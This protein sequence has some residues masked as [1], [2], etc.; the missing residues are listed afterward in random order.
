MKN[1]AVHPYG[2]GGEEAMVTLCSVIRGMTEEQIDTIIYN[3]RDPVARKVA[4][5]WDVHKKEDEKR[6]EIESRNARKPELIKSALAKLSD[7]EKWA[8]GVKG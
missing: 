7:D 1:A 2:K 6:M 8:L 5:W 3:G 4:D